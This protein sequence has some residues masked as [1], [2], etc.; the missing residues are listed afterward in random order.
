M[1]L[2]AA[3][4]IKRLADRESRLRMAWQT[5]QA[6]GEPAA[7]QT[8]IGEMHALAGAAPLFGH[9]TLGEECRALELSLL[10]GDA[11]A[12]DL[13]PAIATLLA[14]LVALQAEQH[15]PV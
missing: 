4:F 12:V 15:P 5:W 13:A 8:L 3:R 7:R 10:A 11:C 1:A 6:S 14:K 2:L 9:Q